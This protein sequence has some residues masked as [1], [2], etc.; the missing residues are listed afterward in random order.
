[1]IS[2]YVLEHFS[3]DHADMICDTRYFDLIASI[4]LVL[5]RD[6]SDNSIL[7]TDGMEDLEGCSHAITEAHQ[8]PKERGIGICIVPLF[9]RVH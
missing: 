5:D 4:Y 8:V 2:Q 7:Y 3:I 1:M 6:E 9:W